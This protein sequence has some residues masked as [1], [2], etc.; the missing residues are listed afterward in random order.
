MKRARDRFGLG[1]GPEVK[2]VGREP[3]KPKKPRKP[4]REPARRVIG[5][6]AKPDTPTCSRPLCPEWPNALVLPDRNV[7]AVCAAKVDELA[8]R[9]RARG[10]AS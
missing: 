9:H 3:R 6:K 4:K 10:E 8:A 5:K 2:W 7:C 1:V